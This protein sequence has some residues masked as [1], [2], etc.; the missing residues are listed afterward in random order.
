VDERGGLKRVARALPAKLRGGTAAQLGVHERE[1]AL[2]GV[3]IPG[4]PGVQQPGDVVRGG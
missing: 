3:G 1:G 2:A 4:G